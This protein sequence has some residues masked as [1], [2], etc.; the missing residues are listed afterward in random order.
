MG[1]AAGAKILHLIPAGG[2]CFAGLGEIFRFAARLDEVGRALPHLSV[3]FVAAI[4]GAKGEPLQ[5]LCFYNEIV[6][7]ACKVVGPYCPFAQ[8]G[9]QSLFIEALGQKSQKKYLIKVPMF[10]PM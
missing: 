8:T 3:L 1:S 10:F 7:N 6:A 9:W 5:E 2:Y 4:A